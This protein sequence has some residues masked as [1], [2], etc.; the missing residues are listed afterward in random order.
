MV[1]TQS[2]FMYIFCHALCTDPD[3]IMVIEVVENAR[4]Q[5]QECSVDA[6]IYL[7]PSIML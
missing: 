6:I 7:P 2:S 5:L 3:Y 4:N 1:V